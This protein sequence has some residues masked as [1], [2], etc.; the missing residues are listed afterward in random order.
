MATFILSAVGASL[1]GA[2]GVGTLG[3]AGAALGQA[4]GAA[5][6]RSLDQRLLGSG[7]EAVEVGRIDRFRLMGAS[8]GAP[9]PRVWGRYRVGGQVIWSTR[10]RE[11]RDRRSSG[12]GGGR[13]ST[14]IEYSYS[15][16]LAIA[17]CEGPVLCI[18]RIW[19]DGNEISPASLTFRLYDGSED[20]LPDPLVEAVE[21]AGN[22][23]AYRGVAYV[24]IEDLDLGRFGNRVP[25]FS[26]EVV[27][28][29]GSA[30]DISGLAD[31][32][33]GVALIPGTGEYALATTPVTMD[34]RPGT[35]RKANVHTIA[36]KSD[37]S[38]SLSQLRGELPRVGAVSL[39]VSWFA[40]DLRCGRA[41]VRPLVEQQSIDG[42]NM[43]WRAGGIDRQ[44]AETVPQLDSRPV[45]GG[46]P[47]DQSVMEAIR[48]VREGGQAIMFY[49]F[50]LMDILAGNG[51]PDPWV[52]DQEQPRLPWRGRMTLDIAPGRSG[53][54]DRSAN[55]AQEVSRFFGAARPED[56][57]VE[58]GCVCYAG[59][60]D[61]GYRRFILHYAQLCAL[62]GGVDA[63]CIGSELRGITRIRDA[64]DGF[65][66]VSQL[67][68]L[69]DDVRAIL[70]V[71]T[72]IGYAAD[73]SEYSNYQADGNL[74]FHLDPLWSHDNIDFVGIDNYLPLSDW[75]DG[76][77]HLDAH[78]GRCSNPDYLHA[79]VAGGE[80]WDWYYDS[81]E[82]A[83]AQRRRPIIDMEFG[84]DWVFRT[85]D[86]RGWWQNVHH[87]RI[88]SELRETSW[89]P[90]SKPIWFTEYGCPAVD[91]GTNQPNVFVDPKSSE[92]ALPR[93]SNGSRDDFIQTQYFRV[94]AE[95]WSDVTNN[96]S[97]SVYGGAM[98]DMTRAF[99][100][101]WDA[102]P[103]P[104]F[105]SSLETWD[106]GINFR[107]GHWLNG[108]S[109]SQTTEAVLRDLF[110]SDIATAS[111]I[112]VPAV[113][114][115]YAVDRLSTRRASVQPL[116]LAL[117]FDVIERDG[118]VVARSRDAVVDR[119]VD[120]AGLAVEG[121]LAG[122]PEITL[123]GTEAD[124]GL[125]VASFLR[126]QGNFE[127]GSVRSLQTDPFAKDIVQTELPLV[128]T[129]AD[130]RRMVERWHAET[131][132]A[133]GSIRLALPPSDAA[134]GPGDVVLVSEQSYRIDRLERS[135]H[136]LVDAV[137]TDPS[138]FVPP[139]ETEDDFPPLAFDEPVEI[140]AQFLDLPLLRGD[141]VPTAPHI[142]VAA[143]PW[144]GPVAIWDAAGADGFE[145]NT[146]V[147][148]PSIV[149]VTEGELA[150]ATP[151]ILDR[152]APLRV[153]FGFGALA[154]VTRE[155]LLDG[156]NLVAIGGG[157]AAGWE[158]FQFER[159]ELVA[160]DTYEI[161][162]RLRGQ[163]GT[164]ADMPEVWPAGSLV[165]L[166]DGAPRQIDL[167]AAYRNLQRTYRIGL[168]ALGYGDDAVD[169]R[170]EAFAGTGLRPYSVAHLTARPAQDGSVKVSW[171][172]RTR[173][174]GDSWE[175]VEVP[176]GEDAEWYVVRIMS[177]LS[178]LREFRV[179]NPEWTYPA[180][181]VSADSGL[182]E[183]RIAVAQGSN[184]YGP[185]PFKAVP[186]PP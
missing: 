142:A 39:V 73:W 24:V 34:G 112:D 119:A 64:F 6:G 74:Y 103:F 186:V 37:L 58:D 84:Q 183:L 106:D 26:F 2:I 156:A 82:A 114:K 52:A 57:G 19:A 141:E 153:T 104:V 83:A 144:P 65:P 51:K 139:P 129:A 120:V 171:V 81:D 143:S 20:Q 5:L 71:D 8:E 43:P 155:A 23:G 50:V 21:G 32:V 33:R 72:K 174:N 67:R 96:P 102:R 79:G 105:P 135:G 134:L 170:I 68:N 62:A 75:R 11:S 45:Y 163:F 180:A 154:S 77:S 117:G 169:A 173:A 133:R 121:E 92:S 12:K 76:T 9:L 17:L 138:A 78:W 158:I 91:K 152:G 145:L 185:G 165:V 88:N 16:S 101:A 66:A 184:A 38:V 123:S 128:M 168:A 47:T 172:R 22:A 136:L 48:A 98:V 125:M 3:F 118:A 160:P 25:Q 162:G 80:W 178:V 113:V 53:T 132:L 1:G 30:D 122:R 131:S 116:S 35:R 109:A 95:F 147:A 7:S 176:L 177:G 130:A 157:A 61:W 159:A 85:K 31:A 164:D 108:R 42:R 69:A 182:P 97:S 94:M 41:R 151:G 150:A 28:K 44:T 148:A 13:K 110:G 63:F 179:A 4:A 99:A 161:S 36:G 115:G 49:P 27:R 140:Q 15:V 93:A 149:G 127:A 10:F 126:D 86:I 137:R 111:R 175:T 46:T 100:W 14:V 59:P 55:A 89:A 18:G 107:V 87:D 54:S 124:P 167:P 70:G 56:F 90:E 60:E 181:L 146:L 166:L 40:D 29:A